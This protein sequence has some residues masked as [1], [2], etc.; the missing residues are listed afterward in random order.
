MKTPM[1][2]SRAL[3]LTDLIFVVFTLYLLSLLWRAVG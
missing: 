1:T 3:T 2:L